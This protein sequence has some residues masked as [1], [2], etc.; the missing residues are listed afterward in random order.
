[1][2]SFLCDCL[3]LFHAR[4]SKFPKD[5]PARSTPRPLKALQVVVVVVVVVWPP[6]VSKFLLARRLSAHPP[7]RHKGPTRR[8]CVSSPRFSPAQPSLPLPCSR[9]QQAMDDQ[10]G[11]DNATGAHWTSEGCCNA[12][13]YTSKFAPVADIRS[14]P[15]LTSPT[16]CT[17]GLEMQR[18]AANCRSSA[19]YS[20]RFN[21][22]YSALEI[23]NFTP[24]R[25]LHYT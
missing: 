6:Q 13:K 23:T 5:V 3:I 8:Q 11:Q 21:E 16:S 14:S 9:Q 15:S 17:D 20:F 2:T 4:S 7:D 1:M 18:H 10:C 19:A 22:V 25:R 12:A 24:Q